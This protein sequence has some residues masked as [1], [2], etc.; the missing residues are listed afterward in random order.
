MKDVAFALYLK[1]TRHRQQV[2]FDESFEMET[3]LKLKN[4]NQ[5][6]CLVIQSA[7]QYLS[8]AL[9]ASRKLNSLEAKENQNQNQNPLGEVTKVKSDEATKRKDDDLRD[10]RGPGEH[11]TSS[12]AQEYQAD[13]YSFKF[14]PQIKQLLEISPLLHVL[15]P[16]ATTLCLFLDEP[17]ILHDSYI[18]SIS[19]SLLPLLASLLEILGTYTLL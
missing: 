6:V 1:T 14:N 9:D 11:Q 18:Y 3:A 13:S 15:Q 7:I 17:F 5:Y 16:L 8:A 4:F 10:A 2:M 19:S 12:L